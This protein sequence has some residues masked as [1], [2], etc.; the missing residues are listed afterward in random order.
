MLILVGNVFYH[1][2]NS[3]NKNFDNTSLM[4]YFYQ[5]PSLITYCHLMHLI[6]DICLCHMNYFNRV[7]TVKKYNQS[8]GSFM[9]HALTDSLLE[10]IFSYFWLNMSTILDFGALEMRYDQI[11]VRNGFL[12]LKL[13]KY[14]YL[15]TLIAQEL[16]IL[17]MP[18]FLTV[19]ILDCLL[20][21]M[22]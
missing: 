1:I 17:K 8:L 9:G 10:A 11:N 21:L 7:S 5:Q 14:D 18:D 22:T 16:R 20:H 6:Q 19:A 2:N 13:V 15:I 4:H 3:K 12:M